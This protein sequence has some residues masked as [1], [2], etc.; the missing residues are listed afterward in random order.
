MDRRFWRMLKP[1]YGGI[2]ILL[3]LNFLMS[4]A[5]Y[6]TNYFTKILVDS[7]VGTEMVNVQYVMFLLIALS[8]SESVRRYKSYYQFDLLPK[9]KKFLYEEFIKRMLK[10]RYDYYHEVTSN[11]LLNSLRNVSDGSEELL[12]CIK[13][14]FWK[15]SVVF[16]SVVGSSFLIHKR[17]GLI[18]LIWISIW[19][20]ACFIFIKSSYVYSVKLYL[21]KN[22]L[23]LYIGDIFNNIITVKS[24]NTS[25][26]ECDQTKEQSEKVLDIELKNNILFFQSNAFNT[27]LFLCVLIYSFFFL[28]SANLATA[29]NFILLL[30]SL[31]DI[32]SNL[33]DLNENFCDITDVTGQIND[34]MN[35][36]Y[37]EIPEEEIKTCDF[38]AEKGDL[39][40][41]DL[42]YKYPNSKEN[43][44]FHLKGELKI[45]AGSTVAI[46]GTSGS[47]KSTLFKLLLGL[48]Q[49]NSGEII[50]DGQNVSTTSL[51]GIRSAFAL[52]PQDVMLFHR[53]L[54][55]NIKY[56]SSS[57]SLEQVVSV[58]KQA[59]LNDVLHELNLGYNSV[60]G[61]DC[62]FSG[63][64]KQRILIARGL[65]RKAKIFLFDE[66]T[67]ALDAKTEAEILSN[68]NEITHGYTKFI[69]AHR[70]KTVKHADLILVFDQGRLVQ[71]GSHNELI[72]QE[73]LYASLMDLM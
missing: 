20:F 32:Y 35:T 17:I 59:Q 60:F 11:V 66:S 28:Y 57:S 51:E 31:L 64:Q 49:A 3:G 44:T 70:L 27:I 50:I 53:T 52:I 15:T 1:Y 7:A 56:G 18:L 58:V 72:K 69:I 38:K 46:V 40:I 67:S 65:L 30:T 4:V 54:L 36:L 63:G 21:A 19:M 34:A 12:I 16:M 33:D 37:K 42:I 43:T 14:V 41:K 39:I 62:N 10:Y 61:K 2:A 73:G 26:H 55:E 5:K 68:I 13:D 22:D 48:I 45:E 8:F 47:G 25:K 71:S 6:S 23:V 24:F 29:G 9:I